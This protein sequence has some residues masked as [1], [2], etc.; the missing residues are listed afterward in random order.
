MYMIYNNLQD[1]LSILSLL[2]NVRIFE[3]VQRG[4]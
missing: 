2:Y 3:Y 4:S 1:F